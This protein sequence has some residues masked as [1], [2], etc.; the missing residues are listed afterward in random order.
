M[1]YKI[2]DRLS[3]FEGGVY[4]VKVVDG[5]YCNDGVH[6]E[7]LVR[8][9]DHPH[10]VFWTDEHHLGRLEGR[11]H[12]DAYVSRKCRRCYKNQADGHDMLCGTC[13]KT[14]KI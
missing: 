5:R 4:D 11:R 9:Y 13:R 1:R 14:E 3:Y 8:M 6:Q 10:D 12:D 2:G 7:F